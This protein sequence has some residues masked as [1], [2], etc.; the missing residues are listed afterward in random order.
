M[1][2][3]REVSPI[4]WWQYCRYWKRYHGVDQIPFKQ[5]WKQICITHRN[6][7]NLS[8]WSLL[9]RMLL[10]LLKLGLTT[11][12]LN[13]ICD[14]HNNGDRVISQILFLRMTL[15][16]TH[17]LI[18]VLKIVDENNFF[19]QTSLSDPFFNTHVHN[20]HL[21]EAAGCN[22]KHMLIIGLIQSLQENLG[23]LFLF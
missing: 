17:L 6:R 2:G 10:I 3:T 11:R 22:C 19:D 20:H 18:F 13:N 15:H 23:Q 21:C 7:M 4:S 9:S 8:S 12:T 1:E 5:P 16:H 14:R